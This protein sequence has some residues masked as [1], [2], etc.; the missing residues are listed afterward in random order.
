MIPWPTFFKYRYTPEYKYNSKYE[1][2][3]L[4][5]IF[6]C[7]KRIINKLMDLLDKNIPMPESFLMYF[8]LDFRT[9]IIKFRTNYNYFDMCPKTPTTNLLAAHII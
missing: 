6:L 1:I 9:K 5:I 4:R 2:M 3:Y 8:F 7:V